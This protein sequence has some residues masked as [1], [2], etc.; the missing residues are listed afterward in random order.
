MNYCN[1]KDISVIETF[2]KSGN[3]ILPIMM[4]LLAKS[5]DFGFILKNKII[6]I[7]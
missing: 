6:L 3:T 4:S 2:S 5:L 7:N 1:I